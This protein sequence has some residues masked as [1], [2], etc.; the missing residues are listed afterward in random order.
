MRACVVEMATGSYAATFCGCALFRFIQ[1]C[2]AHPYWLFRNTHARAKSLSTKWLPSFQLNL[3]LVQLSKQNR[4]HR[5]I[6]VWFWNRNPQIKHG[7]IAKSRLDWDRNSYASFT[8]IDTQKRDLCLVLKKNAKFKCCLKSGLYAYYMISRVEIIFQVFSRVSSL[9]SCYSE[10]IRIW[11]LQL[12]DYHPY[13]LDS[14][15]YACANSFLHKMAAQVWH[16]KRRRL[17]QV[18]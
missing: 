5:F 1:L 2:N 14:V 8:L 12:C 7:M 3:A 18:N 11:S 4:Q 10:S 9:T 6:I 17:P 16:G 15:K 13:C